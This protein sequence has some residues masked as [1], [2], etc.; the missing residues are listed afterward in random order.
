MMT[1]TREATSDGPRTWPEQPAQ[2]FL[3][4]SD[5]GD[6]TE[7]ESDNEGMEI[8]RAISAC[9]PLVALPKAHG[10]AP[11]QSWK[12]LPPPTRNE[13]SSP[14][15]PAAET[16]DSPSPWRVPSEESCP[17]C[18]GK[19]RRHTCGQQGIPSKNDS[20][21]A[22]VASSCRSS[23]GG[24]LT[25]TMSSN[26]VRQICRTSTRTNPMQPPPQFWPEDFSLPWLEQRKVHWQLTREASRAYKHAC[27]MV[28]SFEDT[29][30]ES[31]LAQRKLRWRRLRRARKVQRIG[32]MIEPSKRELHGSQS[33]HPEQPTRLA[34]A[35]MHVLIQ[36]R[37]STSQASAQ[38]PPPPPP[39]A[40]SSSSVM[41]AIAAADAPASTPGKR[42]R[43]LKGEL[44]ALKNAALAELEKATVSSVAAADS[45]HASIV[46]ESSSASDA[47]TQDSRPDLTVADVMARPAVWTAARLCYPGLSEATIADKAAAVVL[48]FFKNPYDSRVVPGSSSDSESSSSGGSN[49]AVGET[50]QFNAGGRDAT[51]YINAHTVVRVSLQ[52]EG[53]PGI[54]HS[55]LVPWPAA[56]ELAGLWLAA[57]GDPRRQPAGAALKMQP[58]SLRSAV[59]AA[60]RGNARGCT[61][62]F[63]LNW[64]VAE[65]P[66][67]AG[68]AAGDQEM[69]RS[70]TDALA[71][72][73]ELHF[74]PQAASSPVPSASTTFQSPLRRRFFL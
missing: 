70:A 13:V 30:S 42:R 68:W 18:A 54:A 50:F 41:A 11:R 2:Q 10:R 62:A 40:L 22:T 69:V 34:A 8:E 65:L 57:G 74:G 3:T 24:T 66:E 12:S 73:K 59:H 51:P 48:N 60:L 55:V 72:L 32:M 25:T 27:F 21:L 61:G 31:W 38:L 64:Q 36:W 33:S 35:P 49:A 45:A 14:T 44:D 6:T 5:H 47:A 19:H 37:P 67:D 39:P 4:T 23:Y 16:K 20:E 15:A 9:Q 43:A 28:D 56:V 71:F 1:V 26:D 7:S 52:T 63:G 53:P 29:F 17:R 58:N 46:R